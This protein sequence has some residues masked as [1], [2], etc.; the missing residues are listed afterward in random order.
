MGNLT[1]V[2]FCLQV[3]VDEWHRLRDDPDRES[4]V[5]RYVAHSPLYVGAG[6][7]GGSNLPP[8]PGLPPTPAAVEGMNVHEE[9][10]Q[11]SKDGSDGV[12][13]N[14]DV[15]ASVN[16]PSTTRLAVTVDDDDG[17]AFNNVQ[18][19]ST[20]FIPSFPYTRVRCRTSPCE[21]PED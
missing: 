7:G 3:R 15:L 12:E 1:D 20:P 16:P 4:V 14:S 5:A 11:T 21:R 13:F 18:Q 6:G 10:G 8:T 2:M 9:L 19:R 17:F